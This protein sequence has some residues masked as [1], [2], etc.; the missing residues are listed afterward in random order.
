MGR[1]NSGVPFIVRLRA[2][3]FHAIIAVILLI[4]YII[5]LVF[6]GAS[7]ITACAELKRIKDAPHTEIIFSNAKNGEDSFYYLKQHHL[8]GEKNTSV[9]CDIFMVQESVEYANNDVYFTGTL[10]AGTCAVSANLARKYGAGIGDRI[11]FIGINKT[12]EVVC[13]LPAQSGIDK[14]YLREGVAVVAYD[15]DVL[16]SKPYSFVSFATDGDEYHSLISLVFIENWKQENMTTVGVSAAIALAVFVAITAVCEYFL[17]RRRRRDY[18]VMVTLGKRYA[19]TFLTIWLENILKYLV[20]FFIAVLFFLPDFCCYGRMFALPVL[21]TAGV[22]LAGITLYSLIIL[23]RLYLCHV[24]SKRL[25][26]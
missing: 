10:D 7:A 13:L 1:D 23:R 18:K 26:K 17:F 25:S 14:D 4:V 9:S 19:K 20:P 12:L 6:V 24:K 15:E 2:Y 11:Q 8:V 22:Y 3:S 5:L 21:F 16:N